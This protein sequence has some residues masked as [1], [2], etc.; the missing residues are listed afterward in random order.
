MPTG[1]GADEEEDLE[2]AWAISSL[3]RVGVELCS[4]S[5]GGGRRVLWGGNSGSVGPRSSAA[6]FQPQGGKES[7][8]TSA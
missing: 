3:V 7:L 8:G 4:L 2:S 5:L 6:G 1:P